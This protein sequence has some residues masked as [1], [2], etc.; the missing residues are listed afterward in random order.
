M[1]MGQ[2]NKIECYSAVKVE[3]QRFDIAVGWD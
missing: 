2:G 3:V 1:E